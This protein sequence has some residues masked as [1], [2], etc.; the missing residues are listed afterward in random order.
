MLRI[1][2][3]WVRRR[4]LSARRVVFPA[5]AAEDAVDLLYA[6]GD[7]NGLNAPK[8]LLIGLHCRIVGGPARGPSVRCLVYWFDDKQY[9][10]LPIVGRGLQGV[11]CMLC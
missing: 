5:A 4:S 10:F 6:E 8:M 11:S 3:S 9:L 7:P 1:T 2:I